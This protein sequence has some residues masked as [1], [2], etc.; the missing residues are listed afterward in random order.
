MLSRSVSS[1]LFSFLDVDVNDIATDF[2]FHEQ[3]NKTN[4]NKLPMLPLISHRHLSMFAP[5]HCGVTCHDI[6][7]LT[8]LHN[9]MSYY[10]T[11]WHGMTWPAATSRSTP[12]GTG[13]RLREYML[14]QHSSP[15]HY[16]PA[17]QIIGKYG[18]KNERGG[19]RASA[20]MNRYMV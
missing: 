3:I 1:L 6:L 8:S 2:R 9:A 14:S 12:D 11:A 16:M 7:H 15:A 20:K 17:Y 10:D 5:L 4:R 19:A 13:V 18:W